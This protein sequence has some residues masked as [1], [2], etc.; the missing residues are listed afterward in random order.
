MPS[1][2]VQ[3][4]T[5]RL[6][7]EAEAALIARDWDG[8]RARAEDALRLDPDNADARGF[9]NAALRDSGRQSD[10][11]AIGQTVDAVVAAR[12]PL[13]AHPEAL[14][15]SPEALETPSEPGSQASSL[16][17]AKGEGWGGS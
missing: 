3:R 5:D 16:S 12:E 4:Q 7:D 2:R 15:G 6:L 9:L 17:L 14:E 13:S 1:E 8:V 11:P 10:N